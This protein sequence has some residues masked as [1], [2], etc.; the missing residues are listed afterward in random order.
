[1]AVLQVELATGSRQYITQL[2]LLEG[3][4]HYKAGGVGKVRGSL[5]HVCRPNMAPSGG[6]LA[7]TTHPDGLTYISR[8]RVWMWREQPTGRAPHSRTPS[9]RADC[10]QD[11]RVPSVHIGAQ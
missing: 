10:L 9:R 8:G 11:S 4:Q 6:E 2:A 5:G 7:Q 1:M 3:S